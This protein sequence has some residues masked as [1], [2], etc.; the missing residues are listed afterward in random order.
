MRRDEVERLYAAHGHYLFARCRRL[1]G[2]EEA[3]YDALQEVFVRLLR[4]ADRLDTT[5]DLLP[6]LNRVAT[7]YCRNVLRARGYRPRADDIVLDRLPSGDAAAFLVLV[8]RA[9]LVARLL[10]RCGRRLARVAEA[11]FLEERTL[12]QT[13]AAVGLSVPTVRRRLAAFVARARRELARMSGEGER[14][15]R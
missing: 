13:A 11:Y 5:E 6:W 2:D 7:N 3:A 10:D 9:D 12:E 1:L 4:S 8:E 15:E 14:D